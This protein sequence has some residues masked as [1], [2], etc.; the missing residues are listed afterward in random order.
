MYF[1][2]TTF[3]Y[4]KSI[5]LYTELSA[6]P[7]GGGGAGGAGGYNLDFYWQYHKLPTHTHT[8]SLSW[9]YN[10]QLRLTTEAH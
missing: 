10:L 1:M 9:A 2:Y 4:V 8:Q 6:T 3:R 7:W 5:P